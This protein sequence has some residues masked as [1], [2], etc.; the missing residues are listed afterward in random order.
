ML[1]LFYFTQKFWNL[2]SAKT[3]L[4]LD[5]GG[6]KVA[7][8][9]LSWPGRSQTWKIRFKLKH[10]QSGAVLWT[11][12]PPGVSCAQTGGTADNTELACFVRG[13]RCGDSDPPSCTPRPASLC[14]YCR[15]LSFHCCLSVTWKL[16]SCKKYLLTLWK[17]FP[18]LFLWDQILADQSSVGFCCVHFIFIYSK[19]KC[20]EKMN[21]TIFTSSML[22]KLLT[23]TFTKTSEGPSENIC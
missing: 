19:I 1:N 23:K 21:L 4:R 18:L 12:D 9:G 10:F 17:Y 5:Q 14:W 2:I 8:S 7:W 20:F 13:V 11:L 6:R 16:Y 22:E 15:R 3:K